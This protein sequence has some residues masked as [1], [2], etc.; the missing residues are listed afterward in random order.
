MN[1]FVYD[2]PNDAEYA[3]ASVEDGVIMIVVRYDKDGEW[4]F[5]W[6]MFDLD[7]NLLY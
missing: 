3:S 1:E 2:V 7:Y 5:D 4:L 6:K